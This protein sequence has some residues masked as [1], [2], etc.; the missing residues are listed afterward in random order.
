MRKLLIAFLLFAGVRAS[1]LPDFAIPV[2]TTSVKVA[3]ERGTQNATAWTNGIA[4]TQGQLVKYQQ[5]FFMAETNVTSSTTAPAADPTHF[6]ALQGNRVRESLTI[7]NTGA[8]T[9][10]VNIGAPARDGYG[11]RMPTGYV[12]TIEDMQAAVHAV[13]E[14]VGGEI[15]GV[16]IAK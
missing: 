13:A 8:N 15:T 14:S 16:D 4:V 3:P 11:I 10:W 1:A 12:I 6:R 2:G 9:I 5:H 7:C